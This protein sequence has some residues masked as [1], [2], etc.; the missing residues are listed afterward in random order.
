[1]FSCSWQSVFA[2]SPVNRGYYDENELPNYNWDW[3]TGTWFQ[4]RRDSIR[5]RRSG[6]RR[7]KHHQGPVRSL[8]TGKVGNLWPQRVI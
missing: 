5:E 3:P 2:Q 6:A 7:R 1:M 4:E 8:S